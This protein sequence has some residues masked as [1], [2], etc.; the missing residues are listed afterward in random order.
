MSKRIDTKITKLSAKM[1]A[2]RLELIALEAAK[3]ETHISAETPWVR[4]VIEKAR[5]GLNE[6]KQKSSATLLRILKESLATT[7]A[8]KKEKTVPIK[9][10]DTAPECENNV[11]TGRGVAP[12]WM[13]R[14]LAAG[15]KKEDFLI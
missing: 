11:W 1:E 8:A 3:K 10:R 9:Y 2:M 13:Q 7:N 6:S 5:T 15:K 12:L 14:Y 4:E